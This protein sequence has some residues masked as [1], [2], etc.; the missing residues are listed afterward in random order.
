MQIQAERNQIKVACSSLYQRI[1]GVR[2]RF[3]ECAFTILSPAK[4]IR[5]SNRLIIYRSYLQ[6]FACNK[7]YYT[8]SYARARKFYELTRYLGFRFNLSYDIFIIV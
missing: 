4:L 6:Y 1:S 3:T 5:L 7:K 2:H 8:A